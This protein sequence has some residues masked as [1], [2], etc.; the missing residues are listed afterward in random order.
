[1]RE[2]A[3]TPTAFG[4]DPRFD[5]SVSGRHLTVAEDPQLQAYIVRFEAGS[6]TAWHAHERG[7]LLIATS[8]HGYVGTRDGRVVELRPGVAVWTDA[9][10]E[11]WHGAGPGGPMTHVAVQTETPGAAGVQWREAV[12]PADW[13]RAMRVGGP[14][15]TPNES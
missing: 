11:H 13:A 1:M 4:D 15:M 6:R 12:S 7:Q 9:G 14:A 10:E 5:G 8:G 2:L 3:A